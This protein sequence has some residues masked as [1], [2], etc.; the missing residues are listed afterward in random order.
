M[1]YIKKRKYS[2]F[3]NSLELTKILITHITRFCHVKLRFFKK[4]I[5]V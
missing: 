3:I 1:F 5:L 4:S 2:K